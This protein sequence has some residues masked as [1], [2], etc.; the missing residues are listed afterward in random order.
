[1]ETTTKIQFPR[2]AIILYG[3]LTIALIPWIFNLAA[4]L[5]TH[6]IAHHWDAVWVGFDV[7]MLVSMIAT[8]WF[9]IKGKVWVGITA[10]I[11]AT[12]FV[13]DVWFDVLTARPGVDQKR[14]IGFGGAE[15]VLAGLT[16]RLVF[17][18][19][20]HSAPNKNIRILPKDQ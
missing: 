19:V 15:L 16:Y 13:V 20:K 10:S 6:H 17:Y 2:W 9:L 11:L 1:M 8:L 5:P 3:A 14:S 12:L 18:V 4:N 7:M